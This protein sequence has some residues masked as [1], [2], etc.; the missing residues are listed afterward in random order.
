MKAILYMQREM[1]RYIIETCIKRI[2]SQYNEEV[3]VYDLEYNLLDI[4]SFPQYES[5]YDCRL[6]PFVACDNSI[7]EF[8]CLD[9]GL[10]VIKWT[11]Q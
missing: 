2:Y 1:R 4:A 3:W 11:K 8:R 10:H 5:R 7:Y 9:D 6:D